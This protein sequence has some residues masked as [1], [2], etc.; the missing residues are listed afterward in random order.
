[1]QILLI[2]EFWP[3]D[4][5]GAGS[6]MRVVKRREKQWGGVSVFV[7]APYVEGDCCTQRQ[8]LEEEEEVAEI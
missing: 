2:L 5:K 4:I 8:A 7:G 3:R 6:H 1:M